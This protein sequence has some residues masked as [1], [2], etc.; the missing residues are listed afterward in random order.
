MQNYSK[1]IPGKIFKCFLQNFVNVRW[2]KIKLAPFYWAFSSWSNLENWIRTNW[3]L[4]FLCLSP[5]LPQKVILKSISESNLKSY[6]FHFLDCSPSM[7]ST[8]TGSTFCH[9]HSRC[10]RCRLGIKRCSS[11]VGGWRIGLGRGAGMRMRRRMRGE[12][13]GGGDRGRWGEVS[14]WPWQA[15]LTAGTGGG[16]EEDGGRAGRD[17]IRP[18]ARTNPTQGCKHSA[19]LLTFHFHLHSHCWVALIIEVKNNNGQ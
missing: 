12:V 15:R 4:K 6:L 8:C 18:W 19:L 10:H 11:V 2:Q 7:G 14:R 3:L 16:G 1:M 9:H 17:Q 13:W 5:S